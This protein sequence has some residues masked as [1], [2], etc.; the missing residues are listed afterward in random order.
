MSFFFDM[1]TAVAGTVLREVFYIETCRNVKWRKL[2][3]FEKVIPTIINWCRSASKT[4]LNL[5]F[6][7]TH[8]YVHT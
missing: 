1:C 5:H 7:Y 6:S 4:V 3:Y 2:I 8:A